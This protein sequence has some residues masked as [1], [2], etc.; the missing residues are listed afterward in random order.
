MTATSRAISADRSNARGAIPGVRALV[1]VC[2]GLLSFATPA[3]AQVIKNELPTQ[4][5]GL[6]VV[7]KGGAFL[8]MELTFQDESGKDVRL[9]SYFNEGQPVQGTDIASGKAKPAIVAL[10]YYRCPVV[11]SAVL[12]KL[13]QA[14]QGLDYTI[15][16]QYRLLVFSFDP[17]EKPDAS[18]LRREQFLANYDRHARGQ[19]GDGS[20]ARSI[21]SGLRFHT[22]D[23]VNNRALANAFGFEYRLLENGEYSHPVVIFVTTPDGRI[24]RYIYGFDYPPRDM[25]LALLEATGGKIARSLGERILHFC[26][27]YD[28]TAGTYTLQAVRV[29]KLG[30]LVTMIVVFGLVGLMLG[31]ERLRRVRG[32]GKGGLDV[33]SNLPAGSASDP[34]GT[35]GTVA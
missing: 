8:P 1:A 18:K 28:P 34:R 7:E 21:E 9:G 6:D 16:D 25:K 30:G 11:C 13:E 27:N 14:V 33:V 23:S 19:G 24:S 10:V 29:M 3:P 22:G 26:Y 2:L 20:A 15:G 5:R 4:V 32:G 17:T 31:V 35:S 12:A